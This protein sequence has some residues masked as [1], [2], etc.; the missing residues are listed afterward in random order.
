MQMKLLFHII[1]VI[2]AEILALAWFE[3]TLPEEQD[4]EAGDSLSDHF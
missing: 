4:K 2:Q 3:E 1:T